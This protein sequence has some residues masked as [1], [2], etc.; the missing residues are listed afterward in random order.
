MAESVYVCAGITLLLHLL[1][2][3]AMLAGWLPVH[4]GGRGPPHAQQLAALRLG[5]QRRP[6]GT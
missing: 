4:G 2:T 1:H 3:A 6:I 5:W